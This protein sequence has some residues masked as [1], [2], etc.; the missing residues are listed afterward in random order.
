MP[1]ERDGPNPTG[2]TFAAPRRL[3][4]RQEYTLA[5]LPTATV[6][7]VYGF[8]DALADQRLLFA[9]LAASA[10]LI[11]LDPR[12]V[13]NGVRTLVPAQTLAAAAGYAAFK[14]FGP[15]YAAGATALVAT[16]VL[17]IALDVV[18]PPAI[19]T[20]LGFASRADATSDLL[21]F[22]L[23]VGVTALLV[24]LE[25]TTLRLL[26]RYSRAE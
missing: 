26:A 6:L 24:I 23:A 11:Y 3:T 16:I 25:Q 21:L 17:L 8:V 22:A 9:S 15:G 4:L 5:L 18:H 19:A 14:A 10:F 7:L 20:A 2:R 12:H 1:D 13:M